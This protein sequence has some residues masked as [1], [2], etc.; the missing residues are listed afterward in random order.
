[1]LVFDLGGGTFDITILTIQNN[2]YDVKATGGDTHLGGED[3]D[4]QLMKFMIAQIKTKTGEDISSNKRL[5]RRLR[6]RCES[7]KRQLSEAH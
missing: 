6:T 4:Q 1:M 5:V 3:F 7:T 2:V